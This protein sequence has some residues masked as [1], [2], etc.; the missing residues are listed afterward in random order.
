M[1]SL[2]DTRIDDRTTPQDHERIRRNTTDAVKE[3]QAS[4]FVRA[5]TIRDQALEDGVTTP[6]PHRLGVRA[7]VVWSPVRG[8]STVG[9]IEEVRDEQYDP[10]L[11]VVLKASGYGATVTIDLKVV[12]L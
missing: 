12:P 7:F 5:V 11:Y 3:L 2:L 1:I 8:P 4:P 9:M 6:I 10:S